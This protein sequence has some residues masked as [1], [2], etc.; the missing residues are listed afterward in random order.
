M[1]RT[2][3]LCRQLAEPGYADDRHALCLDCQSRI[4]T[5]LV[6]LADGLAALFHVLGTACERGAE[7]VRGQDAPSGKG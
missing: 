5:A 6:Q 3:S 7:A 4:R 2:C 1:V